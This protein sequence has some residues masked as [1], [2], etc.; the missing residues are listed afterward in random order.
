MENATSRL[1]RTTSDIT[2]PGD[3]NKNGC[4]AEWIGYCEE[5]AKESLMTSYRS[6]GFSNFFMGA[7][8]VIHHHEDLKA[9]L[10]RG[11]L[12]HSNL[13]IENVAADCTDDRLLA[14]VCAVAVLLPPGDRAILA[15]SGK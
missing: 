1:I 13:K 8:A 2:G 7:A 12:G 11:Y 6:N 4:R 3:D 5:V 10:N 9:F 14:L 15:A